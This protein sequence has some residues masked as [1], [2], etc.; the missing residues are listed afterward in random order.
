MTNKLSSRWGGPQFALI[1][2]IQ[3]SEAIANYLRLQ[4]LHVKVDVTMT[5]LEKNAKTTSERY[6]N[7]D[8][9]TLLDKEM[10][11]WQRDNIDIF[12][13]SHGMSA[14]FMLRNKQNVEAQ[15]KYFQTEDFRAACTLL[16]SYFYGFSLPIN[17]VFSQDS[18]N[19][20]SKTPGAIKLETVGSSTRRIVLWVYYNIFL[21]VELYA[22]EKSNDSLDKWIQ[23]LCSGIKRDSVDEKALAMYPDDSRP[24]GPH[25]VEEGKSFTVEVTTNH[26]NYHHVFCETNICFNLLIYFLSVTANVL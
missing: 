2:Y 11:G 8:M 10:Y 15:V 1:Y 25:S 7:P 14:K 5:N 21:R 9:L 12:L 17:V 4:K 18:L 3:L 24:E 23:N 13:R 22:T 6:S 20:L 19:P 26:E 16:E